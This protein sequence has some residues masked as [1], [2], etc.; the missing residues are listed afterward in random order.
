MVTVD[1]PGSRW[2]NDFD[3]VQL[4]VGFGITASSTHDGGVVSAF[5]VGVGAYGVG[6][7]TVD[8]YGSALDVRTNLYIG[9]GDFGDA[10]APGGIGLAQITNGGA[11]SSETTNG[12]RPGHRRRRR[13]LN[14]QE[15]CSISRWTAERKWN[16]LGRR[17]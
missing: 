2:N 3:Q 6:Q 11:I 7:V 8:G 1:G 16:R 12:L 13:N 15:P 14:D 5:G 10:P 4:Y 17:R 9:G